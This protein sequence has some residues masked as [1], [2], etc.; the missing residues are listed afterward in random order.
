MEAAGSGVKPPLSRIWVMY[1]DLIVILG[2][3]VFY[4]PKG[5]YMGL[6]L[7]VIRHCSPSAIAFLAAVHRGER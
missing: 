1:G 4:L 5:D 7:R 3:S 2:K 6:G